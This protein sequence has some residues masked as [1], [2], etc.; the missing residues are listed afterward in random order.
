MAKSGW[1]VAIVGATGAVGGELMSVLAERSFPVKRLVALASERSAGSEVEFAG[2]PLKVAPLNDSSFEG[3]DL[4]LFSAGA[5]V[6][7]QYA[8]LAVRAGAVVVDNTSFFRMHADV[9]LVVPEVNPAAVDVHRGILAN[10]NCSTIQAVVAL[11]PLHGLAGLRRVVYSTYQS[12][13]GAG[14]QAM[15]ELKDQTVA[16][17]S[18]RDPPVSRF[19]RRLAFDCIP[20][21]D[22]FLDDGST[23]EERKMVEETRKI[24]NLPGLAVVATCVRVPVFVG[25]A[26]AVFVEFDR[27][28]T[29][30]AARAAL[31]DAPGVDLT[32]D[33]TA[34]PTAVDA[35]GDDPVLV[36]RLRVDPSVPHGL[37]FWCVADNL[38]KGAA[39]NAVQIA[40]LLASRGRLAPQVH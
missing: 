29:L 1:T 35:A 38:R 26:V 9:P 30:E 20:Q 31:R 16:L 3:V 33:P 39:T 15:E 23:K 6:S 28:I 32:E 37:A 2:E 22:T 25:H 8:P 11:A 24:F 40:E 7:E 18:F 19:P 10:P 12:A 34:Y 4:A 17:L 14:R 21:I 5:A 13:S 36:G 27:S